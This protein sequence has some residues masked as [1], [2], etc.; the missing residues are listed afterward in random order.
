[1]FRRSAE[2]LRRDPFSGVGERDS[3][4]TKVMGVSFARRQDLIAG[5]TPGLEL[6][7]QRQPDNPVDANAI[8]V[9]YGAFQVGFL[10]KEIAKHLS[11]LIDGGARYAARIEHVTGGTEGK[12]FGVNIRVEREVARTDTFAIHARAQADRDAV[13]RALIGDAQPHSAQ[14]EVLARVEAGKNTIA[15]LGTGRG[16]SFCFQYPAANHALESERKTLVIYPLRALANDQYDALTRRLDPL[17]IRVLRANGSIG[18]EERRYLMDAL[19]AGAWDIVLA[20]PE[21]LQFHREAFTGRST[22]SLVVVDEAHHVYESKHRS[23]YGKLGA[24]IASL[25]R[26]QV[27]A[28]T[29]TAG[30][31]AFA[32]IVKDLAI[33]SWVI[34]PTIRENLHIADARGTRDKLKYLSELFEDSPGKGIVYCNS[35]SEATKT[36]EALR[37]RFK[38]EVMFYHAG[39]PP[40]DRTEVEGLFRAGT[41]RIVVATSAFGE[42]IDLPDVRNVVHYH[43]NFDFT[44]FN[45]QAGRAGR[46][47]EPARIHL[48]FGDADRRINEFIIDQESPTINVLRELYK[49]MRSLAARGPLRMSFAEIART[50]DL[51]KANERTVSVAVRIFED[52]GLLETGI[53]DDGRYLRFRAVDGRVDLTK[54]ERF[55]EGEAAREDFAR[56]CDLIL[57]AD[58][59]A[60]QRIINRPIYP[61]RVA[62]KR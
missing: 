18:G 38:N 59:S 53:D 43:L 20:T 25:G 32:Q 9:C 11:P 54:N 17:G 58:A 30:D 3:F 12:N 46:D 39:M 14:R 2:Y 57:T 22:P 1:M 34:D 45:Q 21:F 26:P 49:G 24:T 61:E 4:P 50:L 28:L 48:L 52:E 47:G 13:R 31:D 55:A 37:R 29:A 51:D 36:A 27:L 60:L 41:L 19:D 56:F 5:L 44:E 42:G 7:L 16:K 40:A 15:I 33:E 62:L 35:R 23:A 8:A 6:E 10:R